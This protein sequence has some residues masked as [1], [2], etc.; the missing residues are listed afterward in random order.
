MSVRDLVR[1]VP[2][3]WQENVKHRRTLGYRD[4]LDRIMDPAST[5]RGRDLVLG[6]PGHPRDPRP[7]GRPTCRRSTSTS[8]PSPSPARP[9]TCSGSGS[10]RSSASTPTRS[11]LDASSARTRRWASPRRALVRRLNERVNG[12]VLAN[13]NYRELV[14]ELLAHQTLSRRADAVA[15]PAARRTSASWAVELSEQWIEPSSRTRG[16]DLVGSLDDLRPDRRRRRRR[17]CVPRRR[18]TPPSSSRTSA[19]RAS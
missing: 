19:C 11:T 10:R 14:R 3:E 18:S 6:G 7:G 17:S 12:G 5:G 13:E 4:F 2:A 8:S 15:A 1:Q 9:A 16:Y